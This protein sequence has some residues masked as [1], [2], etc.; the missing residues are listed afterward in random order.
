MFQRFDKQSSVLAG[1]AKW[2]TSRVAIDRIHPR[3]RA[4]INSLGINIRYMAIISRDDDLASHILGSTNREWGLQNVNSN[5]A[6][7]SVVSFSNDFPVGRVKRVVCRKPAYP[8][9]IVNHF[10]LGNP[11]IANASRQRQLPFVPRHHP[12]QLVIRRL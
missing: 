3:R 9:G 12:L 7:H 6:V 5:I 8:V 1:N 2:A 4:K 11:R 10:R